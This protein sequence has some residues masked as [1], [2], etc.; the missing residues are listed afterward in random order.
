FAGWLILEGFGREIIEFFRPDQPRLPGTDLSYSRIVAGVMILVGIIWLLNR[1]EI[2]KLPFLEQ[3][4]E[5]Y[6]LSPSGRK[7]RQD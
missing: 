5:K 6:R 2:I 3:G 4:S 7:A 1:Y